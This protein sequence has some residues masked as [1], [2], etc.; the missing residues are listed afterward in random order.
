MR[1]FRAR[2]STVARRRLLA[3][4]LDRRPLVGA[5]P[6]LAG[7]LLLALLQLDVGLRLRRPGDGPSFTRRLAALLVPASAVVV[8]AAPYQR[9]T[10]PNLDLAA[11]AAVAV[12]ALYLAE[13][14]ENGLL[15]EA[16]VTAT[17]ALAL[18]SATR[19]LYWP[20][21]AFAA[22]VFVAGAARL[23]GAVA[24]SALGL[25][26]PAVLALAGAHA[27]RARYPPCP[28]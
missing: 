22:A 21:T 14:V 11:F 7:G 13:C 10:S 5:G 15:A 12:G 20:F 9:V 26:L 25:P 18:A 8:F 4:F 27:S 2:I 28:L 17:A 6:H 19:P 23:G 24:A 3:A 16:A 1:R